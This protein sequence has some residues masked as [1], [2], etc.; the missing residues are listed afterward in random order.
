MI[1]L[2]VA[3]SASLN[4]DFLTFLLQLGQVFENNIRFSTSSIF[5]TI[6]FPIKDYVIILN[7]N[8]GYYNIIM[9]SSII[10]P[11]FV[12]VTLQIVNNAYQDVIFYNRSQSRKYC[13]IYHICRKIR[14]RYDSTIIRRRRI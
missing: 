4:S 6:S 5:Q 1:L 9:S 12:Q 11:L 13:S 7:K 2:P 14:L 10:K 3:V 8:I